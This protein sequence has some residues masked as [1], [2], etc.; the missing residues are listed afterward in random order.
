VRDAQQSLVE[1]LRSLSVQTLKDHEVIAVDDGSADRTLE[2]MRAFA[3][4]DSRLRVLSTPPRGIAPALNAALSL[5]R[6][7]FV[8]RMD[9]DDFAHPERLRIQ[10]ARLREDPRTEVLGCRVRLRSSPGQV[11]AGMRRYVSWLNGLLDHESIVRDIYVES[12]LAHPSVMMRTA[13]LRA[14]GGYRE[15]LGP[16]DYDLWLRAHCRGLRFGK[17]PEVLVSWRDSPGRLS[18]SDPRYGDEPF[19][20]VKLSA[21]E[22]GLLKARSGVVLWGAGPIGKGWSRALRGRGHSVLA[23]VEVD[24]RKIGATIHGARVLPVEEALRPGA[25]HLSAVGQ[26]GARDRIRL[27]ARRLGLIEG[28]DMV[29]VA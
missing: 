27:E 29:A 20:L 22:A 26:Q 2:I 5:A 8:A 13:T 4:G 15:F 6:G 19:L 18:R 12:P 28:A 11:N 25:L 9:A 21:L 23:F 14:L 16:E 17:V 10:A 3:F 7:R 1:C 24:P